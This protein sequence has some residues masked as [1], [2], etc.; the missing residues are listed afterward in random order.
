MACRNAEHTVG[1]SISAL[2]VCFLVQAV[3][4][5][6]IGCR[7]LIYT[8]LH[9][10]ETSCPLLPAGYRTERFSVFC[11]LPLRFPSAFSLYVL[12]RTVLGRLYALPSVYCTWTCVRLSLLLLVCRHRTRYAAFFCPTCFVSFFFVFFFGPPKTAK[13][14]LQ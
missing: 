3:P 4:L 2:C 14:I 8:L 11:L 7:S 1:P 12:L 9:Q 6:M 10:S 13:E 5:N